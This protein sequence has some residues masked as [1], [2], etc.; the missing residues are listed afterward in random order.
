MSKVTTD[1]SVERMLADHE[2]EWIAFRVT[3]R[4]EYG[5]PARGEL[6]VH[7]PSSAEA[8]EAIGSPGEICVLHSGDLVPKGH[9][10]VFA[11]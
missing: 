7:S 6:L 5:Q 1:E 11:L 9:G 10:F 8:Y 2:G 3:G 4:D